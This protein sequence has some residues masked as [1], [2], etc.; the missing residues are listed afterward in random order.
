[1]HRKLSLLLLTALIGWSL[2]C[3]KGTPVSASHLLGNQFGDDS[4]LIDQASE[5]YD[6]TALDDSLL[7]ALPPTSRYYRWTVEG[8]SDEVVISDDYLHGR[9]RFIFKAA[10]TYPVWAAIFDSA[11]HREIAR[12]NVRSIHVSSDTLFAETAIAGND[13]LSLSC[14]AMSLSGNV[15]DDAFLLEGETNDSYYY[16]AVI[17]Y[18]LGSGGGGITLGFSDSASL[19][20]YPFYFYNGVTSPVQTYFYLSNVPLGSSQPFSVVWLNTT[21]TGTISRP[22]AQQLA[23]TWDNSQPVKI[24]HGGMI[25]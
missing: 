6:S 9:A 20:E 17:P 19:P 7:F 3:R 15:N 14:Y 5:I 4:V 12:T 22:S 11:S 2:S 10:G 24:L 1:M 23:F 16:S 21:Y 25:Q 8:D 13:Q 18:Q